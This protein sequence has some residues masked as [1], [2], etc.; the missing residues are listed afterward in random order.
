MQPLEACPP[1]PV[2]VLFDPFRASLASGWALLACGAPQDAGPAVPSWPPAERASQQGE[3][4]LG[5]W[6]QTTAPG[7]MRLLRRHLEVA[8]RSP[9]REH[10]QKPCR[11][12][13]IA[14]GPPP[15]LGRATQPCFTP[16]MWFP[17]LRTP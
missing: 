16:T 5:A 6:V 3:A 12:L 2:P 4:R 9:L 8:L 1:R 14:E 15:G 11:V 10:P 7:Q 17:H 13:L